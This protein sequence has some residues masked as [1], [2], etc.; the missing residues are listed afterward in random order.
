VNLEAILAQSP[1]FQVNPAVD[2]AQ[3]AHRLKLVEFWNPQPGDKILE[4]GCGQGGTIVVLAHAVGPGGFVHGIDNAPPDYGSPVTMATA[5]DLIRNS[6]LAARIRLDIETDVLAP[7]VDFPEQSF[8][9]VVFSLCSWHFGSVDEFRKVMARTRK[10]AKRLAY[11]EWDARPTTAEQI[12][13]LMAVLL[14]AQLEAFKLQSDA[15]LRTL[16]TF[17]AAKQA[18]VEAGW[19]IERYQSILT[20][21]MQDARWEVELVLKDV[22]TE[23]SQIENMPGKFKTL[24]KSQTQLLNS[25]AQKGTMLPLPTN[26]FV[27]N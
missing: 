25:L 12:P 8:D 22:E 11:A 24:I 18:A 20:P 14:R 15:N 23:L 17:A 26:A 16:I 9:W 21:E 10:W 3:T 13:H 1:L 19:N 27:G 7:T 2:R 4:I 6:T 5:R